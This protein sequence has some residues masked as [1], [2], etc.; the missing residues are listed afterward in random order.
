MALSERQN[1]VATG[2]GN[3]GAGDNV[4]AGDNLG[5]GLSSTPLVAAAPSLVPVRLRVSGRI[6]F[7]VPTQHPAARLPALRQLLERTRGL[8]RKASLSPGRG[9]HTFWQ[10]RYGGR[11]GAGVLLPCHCRPDNCALD[12]A[13]PQAASLRQAL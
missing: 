1:Q 12:T 5:E 11:L 13:G 4:G 3:A 8:G 9:D 10:W 7:A 2:N 6:Q